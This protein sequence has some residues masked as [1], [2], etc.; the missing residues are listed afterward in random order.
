M[1][2]EDQPQCGR[3][4]MSRTDENVAKVLQAVHADHYQNTDEISKV[5][6]VS[7]S[8]CQ[9]ILMGDLMMKQVVA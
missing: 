4:F 3:P 5:T 1:S 2:V 9:C 6:G 8:S 7:W